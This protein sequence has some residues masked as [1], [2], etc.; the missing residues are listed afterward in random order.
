MLRA[1]NVRVWKEIL[2]R[3]RRVEK[4][5]GVGVLAKTGLQSRARRVNG[6]SLVW[7]TKG[8]GDTLAKRW[9]KW[10]LNRKGKMLCV[11]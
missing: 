3:P 8:A 10:L 2:T 11:R 5:K 6:S 4:K 9:G 7:K 1:R